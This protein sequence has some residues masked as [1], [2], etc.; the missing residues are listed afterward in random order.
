M[1]AQSIEGRLPFLD[2]R[3]V[4][5]AMKIP[6]AHKLKGGESKYILKKMLAKYLPSDLVYRPK[7][8]FNVPLEEW[9]VFNFSSYVEEILLD[10]QCLNRGI[11]VESTVISMIKETKKGAVQHTRKLWLLLNFELWCRNNL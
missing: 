2:H 6:G 1:M 5:Y 4:E 3:L 11:F 9:I 7:H 8:G 10:P